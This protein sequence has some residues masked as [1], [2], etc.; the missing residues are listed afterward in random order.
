M[1]LKTLDLLS[2]YIGQKRTH[3]YRSDEGSKATNDWQ[4]SQKEL[5]Y[6]KSKKLGSGSYGDVYKGKMRGKEVAIKKLTFQSFDED[7]VSGTYR[8]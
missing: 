1:K 6:D 2:T 4:I 3:I 5:E 7:T 8:F